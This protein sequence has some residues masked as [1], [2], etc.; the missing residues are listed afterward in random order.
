MVSKPETTDMLLDLKELQE[1]SVFVDS[2][3]PCGQK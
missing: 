1:L 2:G 3:S